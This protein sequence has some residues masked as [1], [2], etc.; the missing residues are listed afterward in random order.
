MNNSRT[1]SVGS[2]LYARHRPSYPEKLF[3]Y[4]NELCAGHQTAWDCATGNGQAALA[5]AGFF[6]HV[7]ATDIS[8]EQIQ[9]CLPH[10]KIAYSVCTAESAPFARDSFDLITVAQALH[11][12]DQPG[13]FREAGRVLKPGGILSVFGYGLFEV[14]PDLD[15]VINENLFQPIDRFWAA[16]NRQLM[17]GYRDVAMPFTELP[18]PQNFAIHLEWTLG[19]LSDYLRTWSAVKLSAAQLGV[20][21]VAQLESKLKPLW[22]A[23]EEPKPVNMPLFVRVSC[24]SPL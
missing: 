8:P 22:T 15:A 12:F 21:P 16:G 5:D 20:D 24:K 23:P 10:P 17:A 11:W 3:S 6:S 9:H 18:V 13:F 19:Q 4:L 14:S 1:F 7:E 2:R